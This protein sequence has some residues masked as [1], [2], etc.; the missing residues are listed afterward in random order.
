MSVVPFRL[1]E[2]VAVLTCPAEN[3]W[4]VTTYEVGLGA[5]LL[6]RTFHNP[7][8]ACDLLTVLSRDG[9]HRIVI[10]PEAER[11]RHL[12]YYSRFDTMEALK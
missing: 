11:W 2:R 1:R 3:E 10:E 9:A 7:H 6:Q 8:H 5:V 4:Q 12:M